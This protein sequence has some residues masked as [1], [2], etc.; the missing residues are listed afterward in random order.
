MSAFHDDSSQVLFRQLLLWGS[1]VYHIETRIEQITPYESV[2]LSIQFNSHVGYPSPRNTH[3][4]PYLFVG[5]K[6]ESSSAVGLEGWKV[7]GFDI[8]LN[9]CV[10][11]QRSSYLAV[12]FNYNMSAYSPYLNGDSYNKIFLRAAFWNSDIIPEDD[13]MP[14]EFFAANY[15][16]GY[17]GC[18]MYTRLDLIATMT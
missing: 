5:F 4:S 13:W 12:L 9:D 18:A 15:E 3:M 6:P 14:G 2:P 1:A 8:I 7:G 16:T 11:T 17:S 10:G